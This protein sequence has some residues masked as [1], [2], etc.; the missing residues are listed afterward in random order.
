MDCFSEG[1]STA[2]CAKALNG[3]GKITTLLDVKKPN[4][5]GTEFKFVLRYT[6]FGEPALPVAAPPSDQSM[7]PVHKIVSR[8][9]AGARRCRVGDGAVAPTAHGD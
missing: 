3:K 9:C 4:I 8:R 2:F 5:N 7:T 6:S 1:Q